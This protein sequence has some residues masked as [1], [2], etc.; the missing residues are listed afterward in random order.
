MPEGVGIGERV[1]L[2]RKRFTGAGALGCDAL[3]VILP[4]LA[5]FE[6]AHGNTAADIDK[7]SRLAGRAEV[8]DEGDGLRECGAAVRFVV[9]MQVYVNA[10]SVDGF[11]PGMTLPCVKEL[12]EARRRKVIRVG[13][14]A[15]CDVRGVVEGLG[16]GSDALGFR[17]RIAGNGDSAVDG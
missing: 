17:S 3:L 10:V 6:V 11:G 1:G 4:L 7:G 13:G 9:T 8:L 14:K 5:G 2:P 15:R 12:T 16:K